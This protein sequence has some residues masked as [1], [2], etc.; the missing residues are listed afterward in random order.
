MNSTGHCPE[1]SQRASGHVDVPYA[2]AGHGPKTLQLSLSC[3]I[4]CR[5]C[6][7]FVLFSLV[8][9]LLTL[10]LTMKEDIQIYVLLIGKQKRSSLTISQ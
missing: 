3:R 1:N 8:P 4:V 5:E 7:C 2:A 9:L 10:L 6:R